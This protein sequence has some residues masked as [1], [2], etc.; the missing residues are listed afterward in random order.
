MTQRVPSVALQQQQQASGP[1][2]GRS[3]LLPAVN[4]SINPWAIAK[5]NAQTMAFQTPFTM[6]AGM[7]RRGKYGITSRIAA[8]GGTPGYIGS[9]FDTTMEGFGLGRPIGF[10][11]KSVHNLVMEGLKSSGVSRKGL[12]TA[13]WIG[14]AVQRF[15]GSGDLFTP[16]EMHELMTHPELSG[17]RGTYGKGFE[18]KRNWWRDTF[19]Q[20]YDDVLPKAIK[21]GMVTGPRSSYARG[22]YNI[23]SRQSRMH[24]GKFI[25]KRMSELVKYLRKSPV[26]AV[27]KLAKNVDLT[28]LAQS[29]RVMNVLGYAD[30]ASS[31]W[32]TVGIVTTPFLIA[33]ALKTIAGTSASI[34]KGV[35]GVVNDL[36]NR[37]AYSA[38]NLDKGAWVT[39]MASTERQRA[40]QAIRNARVNARSTIGNEARMM[41]R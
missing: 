20:Y 6:L 41:H 33:S 10:G 25:Y 24:M 5:L 23:F 32:S 34:Y 21:G 35:A 15:Y 2:F 1:G 40:L 8:H 18:F 3:V 36:Q 14:H 26:E 9:I 19:T 37:L 22:F 11:L 31:L 13:D 17:P 7:F 39:N 30:T 16:K 29:R 27:S 28:K 38:L 12:E 4:Y